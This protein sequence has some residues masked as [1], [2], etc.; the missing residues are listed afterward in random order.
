MPSE[1]QHPPAAPGR[2]TDKDRHQSDAEPETVSA[3][4]ARQGRKGWPVLIVLVVALL[5]AALAWWGAEIYGRAIQP[6]HTIDT[7][8]QSPTPSSE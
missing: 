3:K 1:H 4:K 7:P 2:T 5:L 6:E 8:S